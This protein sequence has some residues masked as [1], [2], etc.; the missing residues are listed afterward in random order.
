ME[1]EK[2][3]LTVVLKKIIYYES[4]VLPNSR[5]QI[6]YDQTEI[7]MAVQKINEFIRSRIENIN[8]ELS[9][10]EAIRKLRRLY[11]KLDNALNPI[12]KVTSCKQGCNHCCFLP[13]LSSQLENEL[14]KDYMSDHYS[15]DNLT[16][17]KYKIRPK[18]R[19]SFTVLFILTVDL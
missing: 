5:R 15:S 2:I 9:Q 19:Y 12:Q 10:E 7:I 16:E 1:V 17:F 6:I 11:E 4:M 8:S 18:Q 13:I 14:I 3:F